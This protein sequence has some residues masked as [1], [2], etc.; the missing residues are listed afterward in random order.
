MTPGATVL[1]VTETR[2]V[3]P[4]VVWKAILVEVALATVGSSGIEEGDTSGTT[5]PSGPITTALETPPGFVPKST[6]LPSGLIN[7]HEDEPGERIVR[8]GVCC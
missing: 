1:V 2:E 3:T 6:V 7:V 8:M 5:F 4:L